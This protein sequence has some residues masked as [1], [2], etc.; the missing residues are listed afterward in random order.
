MMEWF[1][2]DGL[3]Y[4]GRTLTIVWDNDGKRYGRGRGLSV[5]ADGRE[6]ARADKL[7]RLTGNLP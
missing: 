6:I 5:L 3:N 1:C 7:E 2:L 4:H